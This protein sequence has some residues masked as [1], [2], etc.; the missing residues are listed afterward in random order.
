MW[1]A[2]SD[3][4]CPEIINLLFEQYGNYSQKTMTDGHGKNGKI[5][6]DLYKH[7]YIINSYLVLQCAKKIL[8]ISLCLDMLFFDYPQSFSESTI[9]TC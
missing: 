7:I 1:L 6:D 3:T 2:E 5:L 8:M 4:D 9:I